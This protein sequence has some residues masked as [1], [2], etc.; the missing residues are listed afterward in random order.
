MKIDKRQ[1]INSF[2][3]ESEDD[4][5]IKDN[6]G[7][8]LSASTIIED[9][10]EEIL[11]LLLSSNQFNSKKFGKK[12]WR[13]TNIT[14]DVKFHMLKSLIECHK[15]CKRDNQLWRDFQDIL[16]KIQKYRNK[17]AHGRVIFNKGEAY[18]T[19]VERYKLSSEK[20]DDAYWEEVEE[21]FN[22]AHRKSTVLRLQL[23]RYVNEYKS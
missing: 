9:E 5:T 17:F 10:I 22:S 12:F 23:K 13:K 8:L 4:L 7:Q 15:Y 11:E 18:L 16:L 19:F 20:L 2:D 3:K 6:R 14:F 1:D 21:I